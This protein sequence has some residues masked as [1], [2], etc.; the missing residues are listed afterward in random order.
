MAF[1]SSLHNW[2]NPNSLINPNA[3]LFHEPQSELTDELLAFISDPFEASLPP[4]DSLFDDQNVDQTCNSEANL[5]SLDHRFALRPELHLPR[6]D[7]VLLHHHHHHQCPK[8]LRSCNDLYRYSSSDLLPGGAARFAESE[9]S[10]EMSMS[11]PAPPPAEYYSRCSAESRTAP[12]PPRCLSAQSA[13]ARERRRRISEKTQELG[14]LIPGGNK[15]NTAE[16]FQ[17][18]YKY[19]KFLQAQ[20]GILGLMASIQECEVPEEVEEQIQVLL[21]IAVI[22]EKLC[23]EGRCMVPKVMVEAI[24]K[25]QEIRSNQLLLR[26]LNRF[27]GSM[28]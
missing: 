17:A 4:L 14:R 16:M 18:G 24:A 12:P 21:A 15:M 2:E 7:E 13:A 27:I 3:S 25:D 8:R 11:V 5:P 1:T 20:V 28:E 9:L 23:G 26:D 6:G 10:E 22:Q 19:V